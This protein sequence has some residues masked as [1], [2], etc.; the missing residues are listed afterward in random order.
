M[1]SATGKRV[2]VARKLYVH[3]PVEVSVGGDEAP[4]RN[5]VQ[6]FV[7]FVSI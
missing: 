5:V 7:K 4:V 6:R 1:F 2:E 3:T